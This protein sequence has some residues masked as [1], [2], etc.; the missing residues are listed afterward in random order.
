[1]G[2][3]AAAF[4]TVDV[5][6][7]DL[8]GCRVRAVLGSEQVLGAPCTVLSGPGGVRGRVGSFQ[9]LPA[10]LPGPPAVLR[11]CD[12]RPSAKTVPLVRRRAADRF[13]EHSDCVWKRA[14]ATPPRAP[15]AEVLCVLP[16]GCCPGAFGAA[17][18]SGG[19]F[20]RPPR[21]LPGVVPGGFVPGVF[22]NAVP[23]PFATRR[24][25]VAPATRCW[26]GNLC[27]TPRHGPAQC[28]TRGAESGYQ[29]QPIPR[30]R[31]LSVGEAEV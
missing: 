5:R 15:A 14:R 17:C 10:C 23:T 27:K 11:A 22:L 12:P 25:G 9:G 7:L 16:R 13:A 8:Q 20:C 31:P 24:V 4:E 28:H 6:L 26:R 1:M 21:S 30:S 18:G 29:R 3:T 19:F 2:R